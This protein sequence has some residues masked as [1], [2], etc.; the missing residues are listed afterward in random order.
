MTDNP[1]TTNFA[2]KA[3]LAFKVLVGSYIGLLLTLLLS[4]LANPP[5]DVE[6][7]PMLWLAGLGIALFKCLPLLLFVPGL[8]ARSHKTA[9]W[10]AYMIQLYFVLAVML[11]F[12]P[13]SSGWGWLMTA[14]TLV[15]FISAM[16]FTRWQKRADAGL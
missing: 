9:S 3:K 1:T 11:V 6:P 2:G 12:T 7:G 10:M 13:G 8:I 4:T 15:I 16:L 5:Q 14:L